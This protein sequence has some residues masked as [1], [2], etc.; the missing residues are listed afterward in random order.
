M[1][2]INMTPKRALY[3][4][5]NTQQYGGLKYSFP[6]NYEP[7]RTLYGDGITPEENTYIKKVW[8]DM[9]G[10]TCYHDALRRI[11][12]LDCHKCGR[13]IGFVFEYLLD[14]KIDRMLKICTEC[15][16]EIVDV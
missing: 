14:P 11:A 12:E 13:A 5:N 8:G 7:G 9:D 2:T 1:T 16:K 3:I 4:L 15:S 6:E 10:N